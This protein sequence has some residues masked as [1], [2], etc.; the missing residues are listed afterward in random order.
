M[1]EYIYK[2]PKAV[3]R[4]CREGT[5]RCK[6]GQNSVYYIGTILKT[7]I[8]VFTLTVSKT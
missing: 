8:S 5:G 3:D 7:T 1:S 4:G 6:F 2:D